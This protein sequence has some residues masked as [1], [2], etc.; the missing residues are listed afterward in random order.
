FS[1]GE[2]LIV[3]PGHMGY[4]KDSLSNYLK[5]TIAHNGL[6]IDN[7]TYDVKNT[8]KTEAEIL[9]Y[10]SEKN[11]SF[12]HAIF[13]PDSSVTFNRRVLFIKPNIFVFIDDVNLSRPTD[14]K[15]FTQTFNFGKTIKNIKSSSEDKISFEFNNNTLDIYQ[16]N[17]VNEF[18][19][20]NS[21]NDYRG[22]IAAG[23]LKYRNG[24]QV[25]FKKNILKNSPERNKFV[26]VFVINNDNSNNLM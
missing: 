14:Y 4:E 3:D 13:S 18:V 7:L 19:F 12:F 24:V 16:L 21:E 17:N 8:I 22:K 26:T 23:P 25:V 9:N 10:K 1:N 2:D 20:Y 15:L 11:Y 6:S 5:S